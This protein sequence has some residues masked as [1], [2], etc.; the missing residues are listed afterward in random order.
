[1]FSKK[2]IEK[3]LDEILSKL[4]DAQNWADNRRKH[5][6]CVV[7]AMYKY[8]HLKAEIEEGLEGFQPLPQELA[9]LFYRED[10][11]PEEF[12]AL[13]EANLDLFGSFRISSDL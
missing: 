9:E 11:E 7:E 3:Y 13:Y 2:D 12:D 6:M 5:F 1:M 4:L 8:P 10:L